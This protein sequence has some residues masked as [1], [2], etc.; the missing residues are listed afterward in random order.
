MY[1]NP[2][3][4]AIP[5]KPDPILGWRF[6]PNTEHIVTG[7][8]WYAREFSA[9]VKI[10]SQGF[11]DVEREKVK[12]ENT[13]RIALLGDSM[14]AGRQLDFE[15]TAGQIL[16][17]RLNNELALKTGKKY[18]VLNFGVPGYG[19]DQIN[20]NWDRQVAKYKPD[21]N[22]IYLFEKNYLRTISKTWC[23]RGFLGIDSFGNNDRKCLDV[24][25]FAIIRK[26][27]VDWF[28]IVKYRKQEGFNATTR[29]L[30]FFYIEPENLKK[31]KQL[32]KTKKNKVTFLFLEKLPLLTFPPMG[33]Q[34]FVS[35]QNKY[36]E[37]EMNGKRTK[38]IDRRSFIRSYLSN[39]NKKIVQ[40]SKAREE[41]KQWDQEARYTTGSSNDFPSWITTNFVNLKV[42]QDL[43]NYIKKNKG[44]FVI[45][46]SFLF[47]DPVIPPL[48]FASTWLKNL[49]NFNS[50]GYIPLYE[51]LNQTKESGLSVKWEY[52]PH[53]NE[54]GNKIFAD[55][56]FDYLEKQTS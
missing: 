50:Y 38:K 11:R 8:H 42:L 13:V 2:S 28:D 34:K 47:H 49:S 35:E 51:K 48:E 19:V 14:I 32:L 29:S 3:Y 26:K 23:A 15:K 37:I 40:F 52:D 39:L 24:R 4:K 10:N 54:L 43:G 1:F 12:D 27:S 33:Y 7:N 46:D 9:H 31:I 45:I 56:I 41:E 5:F 20:L 22:F 44:K 16:E 36:I 17:K 18:E 53:L 30:D 6:I 25:P 21:F 55:E